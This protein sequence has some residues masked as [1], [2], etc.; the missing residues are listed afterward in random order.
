MIQM[1]HIFMKLAPYGVF[2][3]IA[4][5]ISKF[6]LDILFKLIK[7]SLV[8]LAGLSL[9]LII[10]YPILLKIF[11]KTGIR[12]FF[13]AIRP[14]QFIAFGTSSSSATLP[15]SMECTEENLGVSNQ[16]TSFVLPLGATIN[17]DGTALYQAVATVFI[18]QIYSIPLDLGQQLTII[19]TAL[20][21]SIGTPGTPGVGIIMLIMVL[22]SVGLPAEGIAIILG[23]DRLLDMCR[24]V[25]NV[26]GDM[27][28]AVIVAT[29]EGEKL[30]V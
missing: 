10:I 27:V 13:R 28:G 3:L 1:V 23:V 11:S 2:A 20:L 14:A 18:A 12:D 16:V 19:L 21:A 17:M 24:T 6:G 4:A 7:Y 25:L 30:K 15:V 9:Q 26:T 8:V 22:Q 29:T 5:I